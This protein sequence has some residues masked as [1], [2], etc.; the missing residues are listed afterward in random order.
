MGNNLLDKVISDN[1]ITHREKTCAECHLV[2][3]CGHTSR[4]F[5]KEEKKQSSF[6]MNRKNYMATFFLGILLHFFYFSSVLL[7]LAGVF[8]ALIKPVGLS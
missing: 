5:R 3:V 8:C 2:V 4:I 6:T 7:N 1:V